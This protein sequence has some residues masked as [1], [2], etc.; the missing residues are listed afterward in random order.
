MPLHGGDRTYITSF[1]KK[2]GKARKKK[3][4]KQT[5]EK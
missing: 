5:K 3:Q 1:N 4:K 2:I